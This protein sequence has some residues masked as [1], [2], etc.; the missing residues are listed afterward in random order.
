M[1]RRTW[2]TIWFFAS[3]A[4]IGLC[5]VLY[6]AIGYDGMGLWEHIAYVL[7]G[8]ALM[9]GG[10]GSLALT[11]EELQGNRRFSVH[12]MTC[13]AYMMLAPLFLLCLLASDRRAWENGSIL[14]GILVSAITV[15][16]CGIYL[17]CLIW[18]RKRGGR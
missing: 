7:T 15:V 4:L 16:P 14:R 1:D 17:I 6:G 9:T 13:V 3:I 2:R 5:V 11:C 8:V 18:K 12:V 10:G